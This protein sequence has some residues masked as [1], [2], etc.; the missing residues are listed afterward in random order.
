MQYTQY[1]KIDRV[2]KNIGLIGL[3]V[4]MELLAVINYSEITIYKMF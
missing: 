2:Y 4:E 1:N 3:F